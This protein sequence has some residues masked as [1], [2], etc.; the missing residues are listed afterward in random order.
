M[1][2]ALRASAARRTDSHAARR[3]RRYAAPARNRCDPHR[4]GRPP[5]AR[6]GRTGRRRAD[7]DPPQ[8]P[9]AARS[10][11]RAD[12]RRRIGAAAAAR[13]EH[14]AGRYSGADRRAPALRRGHHRD[15]HHPQALLSAPGRATGP[16]GR[17]GPGR[18]ADSLRRGGHTARRH[19]FRSHRARPLDLRRCAGD[20][21]TLRHSR[22]DPRKRARPSLDRRSRRHPRHAQARR[23]ALR[24]RDQRRHRRQRQRG[25]ARRW[26][27]RGGSAS[28]ARC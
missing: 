20:L 27:K 12:L 21:D 22:S 3:Q 14:L 1:A 8:R 7:C 19:R 24:A 28:A 5:R 13:G 15:Q 26:P 18:H 16:S 9:D 17:A 2:G 11:V 23:S 10:G 6:R 25:P 4:R